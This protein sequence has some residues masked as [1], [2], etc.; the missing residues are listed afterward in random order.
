M[1]ACLRQRFKRVLQIHRLRPVLLGQLVTIGPQHHRRVQV[2][3]L[4]QTQGALQQNLSGRVVRQ[5][6]AP[7]DMRD[8]LR[9][10]VHHHGQLISPQAVCALEHEV[11]HLAAHVLML[12]A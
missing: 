4:R 2:V 10:V 12:L 7:N 9:R 3:R 5:V 1:L 6:C 11:T 8:A